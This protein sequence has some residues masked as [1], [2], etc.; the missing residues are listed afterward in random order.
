ML[1]ISVEKDG[2]LVTPPYTVIL[3]ETLFSGQAFRWRRSGENEFRG[4]TSRGAITL[5]QVGESILFKGITEDEFHS[6]WRNYFD[7]DNDYTLIR[8]AVE[9]DTN[10]CR[11][12]SVHKGIVIMRQ[13]FWETL[14]SFI[15]SANNNIPRISSTI[16]RLSRAFGNPIGEGGE[17]YS[18]PTPEALA[19][20]DIDALRAC[21]VGYRDAYIKS[22][23]QKIAS[24]EFNP[25]HLKG[26]TRL[27]ARKALCTLQGVGEKV[28]DC[29]LLFSLG[30]EDAFPIDVW[31]KRT[32]SSL[33]FEGA[34]ISNRKIEQKVGEIFPQWSGYAQQVLFHW[35]RTGS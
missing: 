3:E 32:M 8:Q 23:A 4:I 33:Y 17:D 2:V 18:F 5:C 12:L 16:E 30:F 22:T 34:E 27:E 14:I 26:M 24:G 6:F 10:V 15:I 25:E 28:A 13:P 19:E 29:I 11:A 35:M 9:N 1:K 7:L 21:G 20:A 31:V